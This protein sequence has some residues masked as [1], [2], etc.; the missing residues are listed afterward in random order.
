MRPIKSLPEGIT[1]AA[2][3]EPLKM[4]STVIFMNQYQ[5]YTCVLE[6]I[7]KHS[8]K[9]AARTHKVPEAHILKIAKRIFKEV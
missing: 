7:V 9:S 1:C 5:H 8:L 4:A 3:N 6:G 2:C